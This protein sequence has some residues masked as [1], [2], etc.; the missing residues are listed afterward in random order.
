MGLTSSE[1]GLCLPT[2]LQEDHDQQQ[3]QGRNVKDFFW[4]IFLYAF[5]QGVF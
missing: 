2:A 4:Q 1:C 3:Q 5:G